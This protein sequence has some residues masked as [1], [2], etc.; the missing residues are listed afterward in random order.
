M[1]FLYVMVVIFYVKDNL[2]W[3]VVGFEIGVKGFIFNS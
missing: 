2:L 3:N 1:Y